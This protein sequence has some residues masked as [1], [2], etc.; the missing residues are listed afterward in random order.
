[1]LWMKSDH[2][3]LSEIYTTRCANLNDE[4]ADHSPVVR[5]HTWTECVEDARHTHFHLG[6][7]LIGVP[8]IIAEYR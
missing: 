1:M 5:M 8:G 2:T 7:T 4:V 3:Q 6:L